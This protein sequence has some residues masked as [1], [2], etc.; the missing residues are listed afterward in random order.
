[1][2]HQPQVRALG[3]T[4]KGTRHAPQSGL[5]LTLRAVMQRN[6]EKEISKLQ[7]L[8]RLPLGIKLSMNPNF[9]CE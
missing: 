4:G 6:V 8:K 5:A 9:D 1:M 7:D 3:E 2:A